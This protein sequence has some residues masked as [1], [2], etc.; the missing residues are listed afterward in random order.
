[1]KVKR[2]PSR[3]W[4]F[5]YRSGLARARMPFWRVVVE[6][7]LDRRAK[8]WPAR[9]DTAVG[10]VFVWARTIEEAEGLAALA[11]EDEGME[12]L[13]ADA[14]KHPPHVAPRRTPAAVARTAWGFL[15]SLD[16][17]NADGPS[18]RDARA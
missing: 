2:G 15:P 12:A 6:A 16:S 18:H 3:F 4:A 17:Q 5:L 14:V 13:T 7:R 9:F 10:A 11:V 1:M 8:Q